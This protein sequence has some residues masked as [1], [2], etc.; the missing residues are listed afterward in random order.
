MGLYRIQL[1]VSDDIDAETEQDA[2]DIFW[3]NFD[4]SAWEVD[5]EVLEEDAKRR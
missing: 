4:N 5:V 3:D 2:K 1:K